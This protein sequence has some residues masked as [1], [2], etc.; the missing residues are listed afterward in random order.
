MPQIAA[1]PATGA[2][3]DEFFINAMDNQTGELPPP[4]APPVKPARDLALI[5]ADALFAA[6]LQ[7]CHADKQIE[8]GDVIIVEAP[9]AEWLRPVLEAAPAALL[10]WH[11]QLPR[12]CGEKTF[13]G[14]LPYAVFDCSN[15]KDKSRDSIVQE[16]AEE[17]ADGRTIIIVT[18]DIV[19]AVPSALRDSA[20]HIL[21]LKAPAADWLNGVLTEA[22]G[23]CNIETGHD[24][25]FDDIKPEMLKLA[26]RQGQSPNDFL[27]RLAKLAASARRSDQGSKLKL[28]DLHGMPELVRWAKALAADIAEYQAER[29][30]WSDMDCGALLSGPPGVGKTLAAQ[31]IADHCGVAFFATSYSSWQ[32]AGTG[33]LGDVTRAARAVFQDARKSAPSIIFIDEFDT[34]GSREN[35]S[36]H[37][38][39][40]RAI[41]NVLLEELDGAAAREGVIVIAA[42]NYPGNLDPALKRAGRLDR[43]IE[44]GLP[45]TDSLQQIFRVYLGDALPNTDLARLASLAAGHTGADVA[46]WVRRGRRTARA[47]R[48]DI[49]F[50]DILHEIVGETAEHDRAYL[51]RI[52]VHE[53]G[54]A[55]LATLEYPGSPPSLMIG[56]GGRLGG[57]T[58]ITPVG[59][60]AI[61]SNL[62]DRM[63]MLA[64]AGRA[65]EDVICG[66]I[67]AGAGGPAHSDLARATKLAAMAEGAYGLGSTGLVWADMGDAEQLHTQLNFRPGTEEAV[68]RRLEQAYDAAKNIV[69]A[70]QSVVAKLA[71]ALVERI[72][73]TPDEVGGILND[74]LPPAKPA[75]PAA[76]ELQSLAHKVTNRCK[77][78]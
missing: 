60:R 10:G 28:D 43:E 32:A 49:V 66:E 72:V 57:E 58:S 44:I 74:A 70:H 8:N 67:S 14:K 25:R 62:V 39:W 20:D 22:T 26:L 27:R 54:H 55:L 73:L 63:L 16:V 45:D 71:S 18:P 5:V 76:P 11:D 41:I 13:S 36:K 59:K 46:A 9:G 77:S 3:L 42:T 35:D 12:H 31:T 1:P 56:R 34:I 33:H 24:I 47:A 17:I 48:R 61:T 78:V 6:A 69:R 19:S 7:T 2:D 23:D 15:S 40:W 38:E 53:A 50:D 21:E 4:E 30:A 37:S 52:A 68:R 75:R 65:A 29:L 51:H 64:L